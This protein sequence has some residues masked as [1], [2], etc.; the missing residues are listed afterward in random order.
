MRSNRGRK[1]RSSWPISTFSND[2]HRI[3]APDTNLTPA[4]RSSLVHPDVA[5]AL[6]AA[7][8]FDAGTPMAK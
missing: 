2:A 8:L 7:A 4:I 3:P 6:G 5:A 1:R